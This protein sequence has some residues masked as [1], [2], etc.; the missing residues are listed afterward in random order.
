MA[1][2]RFMTNLSLMLA[3]MGVWLGVLLAPSHALAQNRIADSVSENFTPSLRLNSAC[4]RDVA[5]ASDGDTA[6]YSG[7]CPNGSTPSN[8]TI[9]LTFDD[10]D[11]AV[12]VDKIVFWANA[13]GAYGDRELRYLDIEID[14]LDINNPGSTL[15]LV[16]DEVDIGDTIRPTI[17]LSVTVIDSGGN[18]LL[19]PGVSKV[20][21]T[22]MR[23]NRNGTGEMAFREV[24]IHT[25]SVEMMVTQTSQIFG[26]ENSSVLAVPGND[27]LY[28]I[29]VSNLGG[30]SADEAS[31][32]VVD[33]LPS[34]LT[35]F[36][37]KPTTGTAASPGLAQDAVTITD[38]N[39][40]LSF[41]SARDIAYSSAATAPTS[42]AEC[43]YTPASGY[44]PN[45]RHICIN[46]KGQFNSGTP[47]PSFQVQFRVRIN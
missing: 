40:G 31:V 35:F 37:G 33:S 39:S 9:T 15:T 27:L 6:G 29:E 13:G 41:D 14:Y 16:M 45:V 44:D 19:L 47:A 4:G 2:L 24:Q 18:P 38:N 20:R 30:V 21:L 23:N 8:Y 36:N 46:P 32:F 10:P 12:F 28:T 7:Y 17:P 42:L 26:P 1:N 25:Q 22:D 5:V 11:P 43:T 3:L 34:E